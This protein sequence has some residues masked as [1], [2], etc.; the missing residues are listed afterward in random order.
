[1]DLKTELQ[2][3]QANDLEKLVSLISVFETVFEMK[4]LRRPG[5]AHLQALLK[6]ETF[7]AVVAL[8][9]GKIIAGL[10]VYVLHQYYS[11]KPLAYLYDLAVLPHYQ[12]KGVGRSLIAFTTE[13]CRQK[14]F[15]E[16]FVQAD[17]PDQHA[18]DFYRS[19]KPTNEEEVI[20]FYYSL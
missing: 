16:L 2:L 20:H 13:H 8:S 12:R 4:D 19:T 9:E 15:E 6:K 17:V 5:T 14:G 3:L 11:E 10:T 1:M 18:L 7:F